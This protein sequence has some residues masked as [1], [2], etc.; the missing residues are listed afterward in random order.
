MAQ[1]REKGLMLPFKC[2]KKK[3]QSCVVVSS[4]GEGTKLVGS[5][6]SQLSSS[7]SVKVWFGWK[8]QKF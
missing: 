5:G 3:L 6:F 7:H 8:F 2:R 1:I 4:D